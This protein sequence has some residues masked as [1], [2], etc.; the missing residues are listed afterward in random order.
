M[1]LMGRR[2]DTVPETTIEALIERYERLLLDAFGVLVDGSGALP[3]AVE[4][5]QRL[6]GSGQAYYILTNDASHLPETRA[7]RFH[8]Y[9]LAVNPNRIIT[10]GSLLTSYFAM[11]H[12]VGARCAVLGPQDSRRY[13]ELPGGRIVSPAAAFEVLV[14]G[15]QSGFPFLETVDTALSTLFRALGRQQNVHLV[16]PNPDLIYPEADGSFGMASGSVAVMFEAAL[17][18]RYPHRTDLRFTRL[19]KPYAAMFTEALRRSGTRNMVMIGDQL[20]TD[21][22]GARAFGL[23]AAWVSTGVTAAALATMPAHLQPTYRLHSL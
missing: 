9:G 5:I 15:D 16:L 4:L 18:V 2:M 17:Q 12:L 14:I 13:V 7:T 11:H 23:D 19:G 21:I 22:R 10:S 8:A 20:E 6:N 3:G 1:G